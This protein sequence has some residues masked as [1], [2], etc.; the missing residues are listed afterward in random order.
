MKTIEEFRI[1]QTE[2]S[3]FNEE[4]VL[5]KLNELTDRINKLSIIVEQLVNGRS[6]SVAIY[7]AHCSMCKYGVIKQLVEPRSSSE[8]IG[9]DVFK[10]KYTVG[11][12]AKF[13]E[14]IREKFYQNVFSCPFCGTSIPNKYRAIN[15]TCINRKGGFELAI[16]CATCQKSWVETYKIDSVVGTATIA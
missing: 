12:R 5:E 9:M 7:L 4:D 1:R 15:P 2:P 13:N 10:P 16:S 14:S 3:D 6:K 8:A 11:K